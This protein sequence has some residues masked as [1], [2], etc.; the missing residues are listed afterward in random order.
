MQEV[1]SNTNEILDTKY[2]Q[3]SK[4]QDRINNKSK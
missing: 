2:Y 1:R 4:N 3:K